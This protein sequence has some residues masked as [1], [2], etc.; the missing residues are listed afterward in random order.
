MKSKDFTIA[1]NRRRELE[2]SYFLDCDCPR[3]KDGTELGTNYGGIADTRYPGHVF[4][5]K[6]P[7]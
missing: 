6:D 4:V 5:P 2:K 3:C 7:R 1:L